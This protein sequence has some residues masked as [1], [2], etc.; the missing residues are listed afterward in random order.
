MNAILQPLLFCR[1]FYNFF[2][3]IRRHTVSKI[4]STR[5][6]ST[7][8]A[9]PL[10]ESMIMFFSE[11]READ[12][13]A[14]MKDLASDGKIRGGESF[15]PEYVYDALR[16]YKNIDTIKGRQE[17]AEEFLGFLLDGL[18]EEFLD[19]MS[20]EAGVVVNA[21]GDDHSSVPVS[22]SVSAS[23]SP[24]AS[25]TRATPHNQQQQQDNWIEVGPKKKTTITRSTISSDS[26]I[27]KLFG[28]RM[29]SV[30]RSQGQKD[31][32]TLEPFMT[33][34]LDISF[35]DVYDLPTSFHH[36]TLPESLDS[37]MSSSKGT[38]VKA[39]KQNLL[40]HVPPVLILQLKRFVYNAKSGQTEKLFKFIPYPLKFVVRQEWLSNT[41]ALELKSRGL[42][43][44]DGV[45]ENGQV[46][47]G[48]EYRLSA[49]VYHHGRH[50]EG[51][52]YTCDVVVNEDR[53]WLHI[54][55]TVIDAVKDETVVGEHQDRL[56]Y[57]LFY[58]RVQR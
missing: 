45:D 20:E 6:L 38:H 36:L 9:M 28:G 33:L 14:L 58:E 24:T 13:K 16:N 54:D 5:A 34:Q 52:H 27:T 11:F 19:I 30:I 17:D 47:R 1:P 15:V 26:P 51:G 39:T 44:D 29:R 57:L 48:V 56:A 12:K 4:G 46:I 37:Y 3:Y 8:V 31:S 21:N 55:D 41:C 43:I 49:V 22:V 10:V 32:V 18:H 50:A 53:Q 23:P 42:I 40:E 25:P 7:R 2:E 35:D